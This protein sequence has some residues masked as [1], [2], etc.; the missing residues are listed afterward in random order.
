MDK[1]SITTGPQASPDS[2]ILGKHYRY[3]IINDIVLRYEWSE[4][5]EL[6]DGASAFVINRNF[7]KPDSH[8]IEDIYQLQIITPSLH[9]TYKKQRFS[10][11]GP[12]H[13]IQ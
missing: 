12:S 5:D 10:S 2:I 1:Y 13:F 8:V 11:N 6:E 4:D 9:L 7:A 3:A